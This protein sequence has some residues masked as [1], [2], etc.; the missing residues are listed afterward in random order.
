M[1]VNRP[2]PQP[3]MSSGYPVVLTADRT[4][5]A[6]YRLLFDGMLVASQTTTVPPALSAWLLMPR[7]GSRDGRATVAPLGLR[8]IEAALLAGGFEPGAVGVVAPHQL[9][10]AIGPATRVVA[11][12]TGEPAGHGM[13]STTMTAIAGGSILPSCYFREVVRTI[14]RGIARK[15]RHARIVV[16]GPGAWQ[17]ARSPT[18]VR[19]MGIDHV[20]TGYAEANVHEIIRQLMEG[21]TLSP[22]VAGRSPEPAEIPAIRAASTF[23]ATEISRGCGWGCHFCT[24]ARTP[25]GD[26]PAE[27]ILADIHTNVAA[28]QTNLALLSE[29]FFRFGAQGRTVNSPALI[30]LL[31][32]IRAIP[33][34]RFIQIDHAN[35]NSVAHYS[36]AELRQVRNLLA[37]S[38]GC[39]FPWVNLGVETL[40]H[41][42]LERHG[43]AS[44]MRRASDDSWGEFSLQQILRLCDAGFFPF[45]SLVL[46]LA[47][48]TRDD[49]VRTI[50]WLD[51]FGDRPVAIF[52][53]LHA[54]IDGSRSMGRRDLKPIHWQLMI[55]CYRR[56]FYW[57]PQVYRD[58]Q[59]AAG[60]PVGKRALMQVLGRGQTWQWRFLFARHSRRALE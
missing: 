53:M 32:K 35:I 14:R 27:T 28:G 38:S 49:I 16:G 60:V 25:M 5:M 12:S 10:E 1:R 30:A 51:S 29:D 56:N 44:K 57:I 33:E 37:G 19:E 55:A 18:L 59:A 13:N 45:V 39:R 22:V 46:G 8:R 58:N 52:P 40:S 50:G 54:P 6:D 9:A 26:L 2:S 7:V 24:M 15:A 41:V 17:L 34:V 36:D 23:G 43:G 31:E 4:L 11:V 47:G 21:K 20:V 42:L 3:I 48:E